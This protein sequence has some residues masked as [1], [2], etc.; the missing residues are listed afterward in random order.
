MTGTHSTNDVIS[1]WSVVSVVWRTMVNRTVR[2]KS[3]CTNSTD[4]S[5]D[6]CALKTESDDTPLRMGWVY[7]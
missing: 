3:W 6:S 7:V 4:N 1:S 2:M 5:R